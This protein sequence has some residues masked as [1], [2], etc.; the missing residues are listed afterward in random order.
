MSRIH[1]LWLPLIALLVYALWL[2]LP[3]TEQAGAGSMRPMPEVKIALATMQAITDTVSALGTAQAR[4]GI[5]VTAQQTGVIAKIHFKDGE[6]VAV[7]ALL[8]TL[9]D[10]EEK[11][12]VQAAQARRDDALRQLERL[13]LLVSDKAV[14]RAAIEDKEAALKIA[15]AQLAVSDAVLAKRYIRAPFAGVLG[16]REVSPGALITPGTRITTLDDISRLRIEFSLPEAL[17]AQVRKGMVVSA[18][19]A[20]SPQQVFKGV[21]SHIDTRINA[22]TRSL[23]ARAEIDN[24]K[25]IL[26]PGMLLELQLAQES[27]DVLVVPEAALISIAEQQFVLLL[28]AENTLRQT[29]VILGRRRIGFVEV[30]SGLSEG[31][32]V[33]AE[34]VHKVRDGQKVKPLD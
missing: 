7:N 15:E 24:A 25:N 9:E 11:A 31:A 21:L 2:W 5:V 13:R 28:D 34:G 6:I 16:A 20:G 17:L 18:V 12:E 32:R 23:Q 27:R 3:H 33:V 8:I 22:G 29:P 14:S 10:S 30:T 1:W 19:S 4:E 26:K